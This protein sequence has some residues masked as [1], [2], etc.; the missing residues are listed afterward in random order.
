M[1][2]S[3]LRLLALDR[4]SSALG[5]GEITK[6]IER[7]A[8]VMQKLLDLEAGVG[9]PSSADPGPASGATEQPR[10]AVVDYFNTPDPWLNAVTHTRRQPVDL[11]PNQIHIGRNRITNSNDVEIGHCFVSLLASPNGVG[12][13]QERFLIKKEFRDDWLNG[14]ITITCVHDA[15]SEYTDLDASPEEAARDFRKK[16][17][18]LG[19]TPAVTMTVTYRYCDPP[20]APELAQWGTKAEKIG[21]KW[22]K[23]SLFKVTVNTSGDGLMLREVQD[24]MGIDRIVDHWRLWQSFHPPSPGTTATLKLNKV[25]DPPDGNGIPPALQILNNFIESAKETDD[26]WYVRVEYQM[27]RV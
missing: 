18:E 26:G 22:P 14:P 11:T 15:T 5:A 7:N 2:N 4:L 21:V 17:Q 20:G 13:F 24:S 6:L 25:P 19:D 9:G 16:L 8:P 23:R 12:T 3:L 1:E 27:D 10:D